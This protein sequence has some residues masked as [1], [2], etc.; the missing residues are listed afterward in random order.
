MELNRGILFL[1]MSILTNGSTLYR[2]LC[3]S[4][5]PKRTH[6]LGNRTGKARRH[7]V[8]FCRP[9]APN[10]GSVFGGPVAS[11]GDEKLVRSVQ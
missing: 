11:V 1:Y 3:A 10:S 8:T 6:G 4:Q 9:F 5:Y 7:F 2:Q